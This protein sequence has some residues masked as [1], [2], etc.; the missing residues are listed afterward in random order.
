MMKTT[1]RYAVAV[2]LAGAL[3]ASAATPSFARGGRTAAAAGIGFAA[4]ALIGAAAANSN[5]YYYEPGYSY[6][7]YA[8]GP[9]Y[10]AG[11][12][13]YEPEVVY[14]APVRAS[15]GRCWVQSHL[16]QD[17]GMPTGGNTGYWGS[18]AEPNARRAR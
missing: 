12:Y 8:Y 15:G 9:G 18:C 10:A 13:A 14:R 11:S 3:A 6:G 5:G 4:G 2:A 16:D 17:D 1:T 7:P